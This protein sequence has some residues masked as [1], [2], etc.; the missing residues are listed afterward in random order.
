MAHYAATVNSPGSAAEVF[1]YL[2][3]FSSTAEWDPAS[4]RPGA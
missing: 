2:A 3:D 1:E 4:A